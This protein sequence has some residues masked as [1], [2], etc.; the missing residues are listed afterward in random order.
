MEWHCKEGLVSEIKMVC[1]EFMLYRQLK[2][3][4]V[5]ISGKKVMVINYDLIS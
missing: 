4:K 2:P 1:K 5:I 3:T